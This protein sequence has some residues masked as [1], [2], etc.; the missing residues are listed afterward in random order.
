MT[1]A[2]ELTARFSGNVVVVGVGNPLRGDDAAGCS[3]AAYRA[4]RTCT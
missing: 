1:L 3:R 4:P 2:D